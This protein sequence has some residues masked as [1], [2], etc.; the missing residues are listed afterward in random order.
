[1]VRIKVKSYKVQR[2]GARGTIVT[3]PKFW[4][5]NNGLKPGDLLDMY[6]REDGVIE[7]EPPKFKEGTND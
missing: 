5:D 3:I 2:H 7:I 1:M 4:L 6:I